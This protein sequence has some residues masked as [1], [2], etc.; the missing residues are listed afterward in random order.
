MLNFQAWM[1][2]RE[3]RSSEIIDPNLVE[4]CHTSELQ[5]SIHVGLLCVQQNPEDRTN[6]ST[7]IMML[8]NEGILPLPKHPGFFTE[9]KVKDIDQFSWSTQTPSSINEITITQLNAR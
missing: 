2:H 1:L 5:R 6:M 9:R 8:S 3:G 7:V 4:S